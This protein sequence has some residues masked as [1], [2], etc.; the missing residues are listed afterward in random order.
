MPHISRLL[1]FFGA[2][3]LLFLLV[4]CMPTTSSTPAAHTSA[5][6]KKPS[7]K[8]V[9]VPIPLGT[10]LYIY[11]GHT[12]YVFGVAWSPDGERIA[13]A[14]FDGTVQVWDA[15]TGNSLPDTFNISEKQASTLSL[16]SALEAQG[17]A[18][19]SMMPT[20]G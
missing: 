11:R 10:T 15:M 12:N 2:C 18:P 1:K 3:C 8:P 17:K 6:S 20:Q 16:G 19:L 7:L 13:S 4:S 9:A 5:S 14:S